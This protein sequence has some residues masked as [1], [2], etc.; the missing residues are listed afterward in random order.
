MKIFLSCQQTDRIMQEIKDN[1]VRAS[2]PV[3]NKSKNFIDLKDY[4]V[5]VFGMKTPILLHTLF[6]LPELEKIRIEYDLPKLQFKIDPFLQ[7]KSKD[8]MKYVTSSEHITTFLTNFQLLDGSLIKNPQD[9]EQFLFENGVPKNWMDKLHQ[10]DVLSLFSD[11]SNINNKFAIRWL[12]KILCAYNIAGCLTDVINL[13]HALGFT[14]ED[15]IMELYWDIIHN[16][17][18][19]PFG[20]VS[21]Q[22][23]WIPDILIHDGELDDMLCFILLKYL[24]PNLVVK[25]QIPSIEEIIQIT[26]K[27]EMFGWE[28]IIDP[29]SRNE[30]ALSNLLA[31]RECVKNQ[32]KKEKFLEKKNL[33]TK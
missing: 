16:I 26:Q 1:E 27:F 6:Q 3:F 14:S 13:I 32:E 33:Q 29:N 30:I 23:L 28:I 21:Q 5:P 17:V 11:S 12:S 19:V 7:T 4:D 31:N 25:M 10:D 2:S 18:K 22:E 9:W 8:L 20:G 24:N 15:N